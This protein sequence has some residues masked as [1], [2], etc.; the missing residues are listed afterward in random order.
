M[1]AN[2][3]RKCFKNGD[4]WPD[5][6]WLRQEIEAKRIGFLGEITSQHLGL[7]PDDPKMEPY[8]ALAEELDIPVL[9]H[10]GSDLPGAAYSGSDLE[11]PWCGEEPCAPNFRAIMSQPMLLAEVLIRHLG[12]DESIP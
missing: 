7:P 6:E 2:G 4:T 11:A 3:G 12:S 1:V 9:I 8:Y 10:I 5:I